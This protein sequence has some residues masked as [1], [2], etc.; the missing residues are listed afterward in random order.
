MQDHLIPSANM[1]LVYCPRADAYRV[2]LLANTGAISVC[3][4]L[5]SRQVEGLIIDE[6]AGT[7]QFDAYFLLQDMDG[8]EVVGKSVQL[9]CGTRNDRALYAI[10]LAIQELRIDL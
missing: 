1:S 7:K 4:P 10:Q 5:S 8:I 9:D 2:I 3:I 6:H